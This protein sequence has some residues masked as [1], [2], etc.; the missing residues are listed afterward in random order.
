MH[1]RLIILYIITL[2]CITSCNNNNSQE[3]ESTPAYSNP[4]VINYTKAIELTPDDASLYYKRSM[5]LSNINQDELAL[6][7]LNKAIELDPKNTS[8]LLGKGEVLNYL[9]KYNEAVIT[10]NKALELTPNEIQI[11]LMIAK[12]LL[13]D[14]KTSS[15][16]AIVQKILQQHPDYPDAYYWKA[17]VAAAEKDTAE[18]ILDL[19]TALDIDAFF[20]EASLLLADYYAETNNILCVSQYKRTFDLD[21]TD[22]YPIFQTGYYFENAKN[23]TK[24][25]TAYV[26]CISLNHDYTDAYLQLGRIYLAEDSLEKAKRNLQM[27]VFTEPENTRTHYYLGTVYERMS[28]KDSA[29]FYYSNAYNLNKHYKEAAEALKR[30]K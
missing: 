3:K 11:N 23:L 26:E 19:K 15:A 2:A 5:A 4:S 16:K 25:K 28:I 12:S 10:Y 14:K 27:A 30:L 22:V 24:A 17:Q 21:T 29:K 1:V 13:L 6:I 20:Y 18:A 8:Y 7:D 9:E